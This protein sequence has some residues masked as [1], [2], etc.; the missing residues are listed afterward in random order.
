MERVSPSWLEQCINY[1]PVEF[2][3][4]CECQH[5]LLIA[6]GYHGGNQD[7]HRLFHMRRSG[8]TLRR[9]NFGYI[10]KEFGDVHDASVAQT[11]LSSFM[12]EDI[13][14]CARIDLGFAMLL[15]TYHGRSKRFKQ[16]AGAG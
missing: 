1:V 8:A 2:S 3:S 11:N 9:Q 15:K 6:T 7:T 13:L 12:P 10:N 14:H 16:K 4:D 5:R